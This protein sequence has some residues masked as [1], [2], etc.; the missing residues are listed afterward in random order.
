MNCSPAVMY[1]VSKPYISETSKSEPG[2]ALLAIISSEHT[3]QRI[4]TTAKNPTF[5][6]LCRHAQIEQEECPQGSERQETE[7]G[8]NHSTTFRSCH[9]A[10]T[11]RVSKRGK[12]TE[13]PLCV[14]DYNHNMGGADLKDQ[15][16]YMY[17]VERNGT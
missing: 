7:K 9:S 12:E 14:I 15:L 13:K 4:N 3:Q 6:Q 5:H 10:D 8:R 17:V 11:Q 1:S 16:L 2:Y